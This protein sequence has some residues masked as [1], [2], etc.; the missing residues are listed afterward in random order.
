MHR[1]ALFPQPVSMRSSL[2][3]QRSMMRIAVSR[4]SALADVLSSVV[5]GIGRG[6]GEMISPGRAQWPRHRLTSK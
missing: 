5:V 4:C 6:F 2:T 1:L 3:H